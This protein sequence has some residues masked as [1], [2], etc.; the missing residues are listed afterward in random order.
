MSLRAIGSRKHSKGFSLLELVVVITVIGILAAIALPAYR[1]SIRKSGRTGA[2]GALMDLALRQE[3]FF[4]NNRSYSDSLAGLGLP[5]P[6][7]VNSRSEQVAATDTQGLYAITLANVTSTSYDAVA[8]AVND[9]SEDSC[10]NY[11][12]TSTGTRQASGAA[13]S[14]VCW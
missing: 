7:V 12:L 8:T 2:K 9:Q 6:Y 1:E 4:L 11:T 5:D 10:G 14:S 13:G 3:Q